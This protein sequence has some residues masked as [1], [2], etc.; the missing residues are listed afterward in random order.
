MKFIVSFH[1]MDGEKFDLAVHPD[2]MEAFV[3]AIS[4]GEVYFNFKRGAGV[5]IPI[6]KI[7]HFQVKH[8]DEFGKKVTVTKDN[9]VIDNVKPG[10]KIEH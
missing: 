9:P 6:D 1:Y 7:R 4:A 10:V 8:V 5:W 3:K 2:D